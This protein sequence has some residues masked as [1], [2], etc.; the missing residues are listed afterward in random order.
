MEKL[1]S[2][3][4]ISSPEQFD[5]LNNNSFSQILDLSR[6]QD[7]SFDLKREMAILKQMEPTKPPII[8]NH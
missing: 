8:I 5:P 2:K 1:E 7:K 6:S 3:P 4:R